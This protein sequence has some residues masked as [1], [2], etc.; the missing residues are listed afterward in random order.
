MKIRET[1]EDAGLVGQ[2]GTIRG[3]SGGTCSVFLPE[4]DRVVNIPGE[5]LEPVAPSRG[6]RV[7]VIMGE[8]RESTGVLLSFDNPDGVVKSDDGKIKMLDMNFLCKMNAG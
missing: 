2:V 6:D 4:E 3:I 1:H 7:K 8:E 5:H